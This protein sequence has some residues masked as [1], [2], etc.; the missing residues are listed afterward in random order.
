MRFPVIIQPQST[1]CP[2][3]VPAHAP[4]PA[5]TPRV[6]WIPRSSRQHR[7]P[8]GRGSEG[9]IA[10][11]GSHGKLTGWAGFG[12][13]HGIRK[14]AVRPDELHWSARSACRKA[15]MH[16]RARRAGERAIPG[17]FAVSV[18]AGGR[19]TLKAH[20]DWKVALYRGTEPVHRLFHRL[21]SLGRSAA[22]DSHCAETEPL[23]PDH[24]RCTSGAGCTVDP[25][26]PLR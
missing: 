24:A 6:L 14:P 4:T 5:C 23:D 17:C 1:S 13:S 15:R 12:G 8:Y 18:L 7:S 9:R 3:A 2:P 25:L 21:T 11:G 22:Y 16:A 26:K 20:D 10:F 19:V